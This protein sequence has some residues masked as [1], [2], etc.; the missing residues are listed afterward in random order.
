MK[1]KIRE[2]KLSQK[3]IDFGERKIS[4]MNFSHIVTIPK[5]FVQSTPYERIT[6]VRIT[7]LEDGCLKLTPVRAKNGDYEVDLLNP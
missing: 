1:N 2:S 6:T 4:K 7:M 5:I 3:E